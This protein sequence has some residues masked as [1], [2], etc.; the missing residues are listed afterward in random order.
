[1]EL[2]RA[3]RPRFVPSLRPGKAQEDSERARSE[4]HFAVLEQALERVAGAAVL[5][6][7]DGGIEHAS[8]LACEL[9]ARWFASDPVGALPHALAGIE[10]T[11]TF[12][13]PEAR[14]VVTRV[15]T[16]P[17]LLL[18]DETRVRPDPERAR[19]LGLTHRET[20]VLVL[21]GAGRTDAQIAEE[22]VI[23]PRTV[24]KHLE[25]AFDKLG[26]RDRRGAADMLL[27]AHGTGR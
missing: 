21:A 14:L 11:K 22:L 13:R 19:T 6:A 17:P 15:N 3:I 18:L 25:H 27:N 1:M 24:Q 2:S 9:L 12:E 10:Y 26:T 16:S 5:I 20:E 8:E 4:R 7:E 23:S